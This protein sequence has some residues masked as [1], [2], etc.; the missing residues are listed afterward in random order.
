MLTTRSIE[1]WSRLMQVSRAMTTI[2]DEDLKAA[3]FPSAIWY[4][5]LLALSQAGP[6]GLRPYAMRQKLMIPQYTVSRLMDRMEAA[7]VVERVPCAE[8][9]RGQIL[10]AR[11]A[12]LELLDDM[13]PVYRDAIAARLEGRIDA[14]A[15]AQFGETLERLTPDD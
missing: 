13:W 11:D 2:V 7:G 9:G 6:A 4:E 15:L 5:V 10:R 8:D 3:G 12:G 1:A 14:A